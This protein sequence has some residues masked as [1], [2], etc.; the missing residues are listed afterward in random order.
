MNKKISAGLLMYRWKGNRMEVFL[1]HP[2]GPFF[3]KKDHGTWSIPKGELEEG[4]D[5]LDCAVREFQ[6]EIGF[7]PQGKF[8]ALGNIQQKGG[9]VVHAWAFEGDFKNN[10]TLKSNTFEIEWPPRSGRIESFPEIDRAEFFPLPEA[11]LKIN[12]AQ[13]EFLIRLEKML[14]RQ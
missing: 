14:S 2:G 10:W 8:I 7:Q 1:V 4:E 3:A 9:T 11:K 12:P 13:V 5:F 6:E